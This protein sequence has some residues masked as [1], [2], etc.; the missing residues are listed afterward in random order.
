M[1][2][3]VHQALRMG[4]G[5]IA[6]QF[7]DLVAEIHVP[8]DFA[9]GQLT[10]QYQLVVVINQKEY[11]P[12]EVILKLAD[13]I[14]GPLFIKTGILFGLTIL[15]EREWATLRTSQE[16]EVS[17]TLGQTVCVWRRK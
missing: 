17:S 6:E 1:S 7:G 11:S 16:V 9:Q 3:N 13:A 5:S 14:F 15:S 12:I 4:I 10:G 8:E 2:A